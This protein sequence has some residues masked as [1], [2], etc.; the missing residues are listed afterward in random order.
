MEKKDDEDDDDGG[1]GGGG[2]QDKVQRY[3]QHHSRI[4]ENLTRTL[5]YHPL[6]E[7]SSSFS[8]RSITQIKSKRNNKGIK[9]YI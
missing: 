2:S 8:F 1:G 4:R 6:S 5:H 9:V 3:L 7:Y